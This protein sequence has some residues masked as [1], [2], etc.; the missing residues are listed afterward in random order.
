MARRSANTDA[1]LAYLTA[2][3]PTLARAAPTPR[4]DCL[5]AR[6]SAATFYLALH[7]SRAYGP[8]EPMPRRHGMA[9]QPVAG[10]RQ[11][12][13]WW[14]ALGANSLH[15]GLPCCAPCEGTDVTAAG[16]QLVPGTQHHALHVHGLDPRLSRCAMPSTASR[17][18]GPK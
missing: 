11:R 17:R 7:R 6:I 14:C 4:A 1:A 18:I 8:R 5:F 2:R 13:P 3:Y 15:G 10:E 12:H 16:T 9:C